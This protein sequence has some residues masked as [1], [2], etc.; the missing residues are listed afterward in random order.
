MPT[1]TESRRAISSS[2]AGRG[3]RERAGGRQSADGGRA[4]V[5]QPG[6]IRLRLAGSHAPQRL[7]TLMWG[8]LARPAA[9]VGSSPKFGLGP[10]QTKSPARRDGAWKVGGSNYE[11]FS[12]FNLTWLMAFVGS[13]ALRLTRVAE[14]AA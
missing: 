5:E 9:G 1:D 11:S 10:G 7:V 4:D 13:E 6:D 14:L 2:Q 8:E 12:G 3:G